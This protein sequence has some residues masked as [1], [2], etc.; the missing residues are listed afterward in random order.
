VRPQFCYA[1][2]EDGGN[3]I[4][5]RPV[6]VEK[7]ASPSGGLNPWGDVDILHSGTAEFAAGV[8]RAVESDVPNAFAVGANYRA[9][10]HGAR[11][12]ARRSLLFDT[13]S[14]LANSRSAGVKPTA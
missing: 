1:D 5:S 14:K 6:F 7:F 8:L 12:I 3:D 2:F 11:R 10:H 4:W 9:F 13:P